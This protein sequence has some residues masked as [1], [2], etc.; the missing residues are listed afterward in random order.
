MQ[1]SAVCIAQLVN[2]YVHCCFPVKYG[3]SCNVPILDAFCQNVFGSL[4]IVRKDL[5][6]AY[7]VAADAGHVKYWLGAGRGGFGLSGAECL[8]PTFYC[9]VYIEPVGDV[10][11]E[12]A[13]TVKT[14]E[15]PIK[16]SFFANV[17]S[18]NYLPNALNVM[19]AQADG[20]DQVLNLLQH[21]S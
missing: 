16:P 10:D 21:V 2:E 12:R 9:Q 14:S 1:L 8:G 7:Q 13:L 15:V 3:L 11:G 20:F 4:H 5:Q 17:K 18:N 19:D 6:N